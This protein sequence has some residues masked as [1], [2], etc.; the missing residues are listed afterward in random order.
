MGGGCSEPGC[1]CI[2]VR[3]RLSQA[4]LGLG[5]MTYL[6][7]Q[8]AELEAKAAEFVLLADQATDTKAQDLNTRIAQELY[9]TVDVLKR[10]SRL[11]L[12]AQ[13]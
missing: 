4:D 9:S 11:T 12:P 13:G 8:I 2:S 7:S 3:G 5:A 10:S 6:E 1:V